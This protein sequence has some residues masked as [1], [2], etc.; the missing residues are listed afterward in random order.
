MHARRGL[1]VVL[2]TAV[3]ITGCGDPA[4]QVRDPSTGEL[5]APSTQL[6]TEGLLRGVP[7]TCRL[8]E[9]VGGESVAAQDR[10]IGAAV[11]ARVSPAVDRG[12]LV[13]VADETGNTTV[14]ATLF[15]VSGREGDTAL[16][17]VRRGAP[18][19]VVAVNEVAAA[20]SDV[21]L[22]LMADPVT[23]AAAEATDCSWVGA[24]RS[25]PD[26]PE[27]E[28]QM[29]PDLLVLDPAQVMPGAIVEMHFPEETMRGIA[30][31]LDRRTPAGW[32]LRYWLTSDGNGG[33]PNW[34]AA[35]TEGFGWEDVG[36]GG[37]GPDHVR[38]PDDAEPGSYR[39][40]TANA[41]E[42]FCAPLEVVQP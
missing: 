31:Q 16:W 34:A 22:E 2:S 18:S 42:D 39:L 19:R 40:C 33:E 1:G 17:Q 35:G 5:P 41:G 21:P 8:L 20:I 27:P 24:D 38:I 6:V 3:L 26:P 7:D 23:A 29:R 11:A 13:G 37:P 15:D 28:P 30:F 32:E 12:P 36:V 10:E 25:R 9:G 4:L 14:A